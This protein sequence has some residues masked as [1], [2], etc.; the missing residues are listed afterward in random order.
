MFSPAIEHLTCLLFFRQLR[1]DVRT[2]ILFHYCLAL[3]ISSFLIVLS[4]VIALGD[5]K[6]ACQ[7]VAILLHYFT[8]A[9]FS[10]MVVEAFFLYRSLVAV[11]CQEIS[12]FLAKCAAFGWGRSTGPLVSD[13][14]KFS[15][16]AKVSISVLH[17]HV[18]N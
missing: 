14:W 7:A 11:F 8:T 9:I 4:S 10:W 15:I 13:L 5:N 1:H 12:H 18:H 2:Q 17:Y 6:K 3:G 16:G